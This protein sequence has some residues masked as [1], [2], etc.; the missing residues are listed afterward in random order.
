[1]MVL[2]LIIMGILLNLGGVFS[3]LLPETLH[4]HL[5]QTLEEGEEFGK[6]WTLADYCTCCPKRWVVAKMLLC[7]WMISGVSSL[8]L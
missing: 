5:P 1:M 8:A 6:H 3:L 7:M 4:Q 2:P